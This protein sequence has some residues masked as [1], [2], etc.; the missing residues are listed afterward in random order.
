MD[1]TKADLSQLLP[2]G[3]GVLA[4]GHWLLLT[5]AT[6]SVSGDLEMLA[7]PG[8]SDLEYG[9]PTGP[10]WRGFECLAVAE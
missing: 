4:W 10:I 5:D 1:R 3:D 8:G 6:R 2:A 7:T 9:Q